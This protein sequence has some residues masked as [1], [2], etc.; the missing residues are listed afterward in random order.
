LL[1]C[2][3]FFICVSAAAFQQGKI[4]PTPFP[5]APPPGGSLL[6]HLNISGPLRPGMRQARP[7]G[8]PPM[9]YPSP[10]GMMPGGGPSMRPPMGGPTQMM[11][12]P[13]VTQPPARPVISAIRTGVSRFAL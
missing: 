2:K 13:H 10:H 12:G 8:G 1:K 11:P 4:P 6:P 5:G 7:M 9:V 3:V